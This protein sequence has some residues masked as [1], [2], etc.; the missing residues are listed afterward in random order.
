[1]KV[2]DNRGVAVVSLCRAEEKAGV[3]ERKIERDWKMNKTMIDA[4]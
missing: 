4:Q 2:N 3:I 1:M